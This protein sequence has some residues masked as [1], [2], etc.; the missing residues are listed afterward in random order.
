M[1]NVASQAKS[2]PQG[3]KASEKTL[4]IVPAA[5]TAESDCGAGSCGCGC[6]LPIA[7]GLR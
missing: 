1:M 2:R 6:G 5:P 7:R 3:P 4:P